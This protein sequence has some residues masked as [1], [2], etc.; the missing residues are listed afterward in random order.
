MLGSPPPTHTQNPPLPTTTPGRPRHPPGHYL[1]GPT[2]SQLG[3][4]EDSE[5]GTSGSTSSQRGVA[6]APRCFG[7]FPNSRFQSRAEP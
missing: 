7:Y 1:A 4:D 2:Q 5:P 3:P 6:K